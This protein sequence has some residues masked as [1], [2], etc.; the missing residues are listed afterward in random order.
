M[1]LH[2][3]ALMDAAPRRARHLP[4]HGSRRAPRQVPRI[5]EVRVAATCVDGAGHERPDTL[6]EKLVAEF[7]RDHVY[8]RCNF[9]PEDPPAIPTHAASSPE[10][11]AFESRL[12]REL[13]A[14]SAALKQSVPLHNPRYIGHMESGLLLPAVAAQVPQGLRFHHHAAPGSAGSRHRAG[15]APL[16]APA[17][18]LAESHK[19]L[20][21]PRHTLM[22]PFLQGTVN[23]IGHIDCHFEFVERRI[24]V[25]A[26]AKAVRKQRR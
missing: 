14:L 16:P 17:V 8:S 10:Y 22:N 5:T 11:R 6:L 20:R 18:A 4:W 2:A 13:H 3:V 15:V 21:I 7:L 25:L 9:H 24:S 23:G 19:P 12:R 1:A 26:G